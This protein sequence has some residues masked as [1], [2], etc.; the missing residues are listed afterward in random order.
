MK[1]RQIRIN[2]IRTSFSPLRSQSSIIVVVIKDLKGILFCMCGKECLCS[3]IQWSDL[4]VIEHLCSV[5]FQIS[6]SLNSGFI[7]FILNTIHSQI[8]YPCTV[9]GIRCIYSVI[10]IANHIGCVSHFLGIIDRLLYILGRSRVRLNRSYH[11]IFCQIA[12]QNNGDHKISCLY[13]A[14]IGFIKIEAETLEF[15]K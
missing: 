7:N 8:Y 9:L 15:S 14:A 2:C 13:I 6:A 10:C 11:L 12:R 5:R 4:I 3:S 1:S